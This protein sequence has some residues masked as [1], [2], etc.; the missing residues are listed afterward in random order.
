M[1]TLKKLTA[2]S[3]MTVLTFCGL[4]SAGGSGTP[5]APSIHADTRAAQQNVALARQ[6]YLPFN[7]GDV[8]VYSRI[9]TKDWVDDALQ[10]GQA[11]GYAGFTPV[12]QYFR[13]TMPDLH[14]ENMD[15]TASGDR[16]V[17]RSVISGTP[18]SPF[19]GVAPNGKKI[20]FRA[21]DIH[22]I[23]NGQIVYTWHLEDLFSA[24]AQLSAK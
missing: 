10:P 11:L 5:T 12:I 2:L 18:V 19:L 6:F 23:K 4:A 1:T 20:S 21:I 9:L 3:L 22:Q 16:V 13:A 17:V 7:T 24:A 8:S 15:I 14:V